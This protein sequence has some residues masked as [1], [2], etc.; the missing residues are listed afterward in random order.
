M[1]RNNNNILDPI[2]TMNW[3]ARPLRDD[4]DGYHFLVT[5]DDRT[6]I[7]DTAQNAQAVIEQLQA[8]NAIFKEEARKQFFVSEKYRE[9]LE[10]LARLGNG[11]EYGNSDGN[12]IAQQ[13]L[14][15]R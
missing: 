6:M 11:T 7:L 1:V 12:I 4:Y 8:E 5:A 15:K 13:A 3:P 14:K 2:L 10:K 9:V